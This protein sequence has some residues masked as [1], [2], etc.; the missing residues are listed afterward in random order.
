MATKITVGKIGLSPTKIAIP[1]KPNKKNKK[2]NK[3]EKAQANRKHI[4]GTK[5]QNDHWHTC[6]AL[7]KHWGFNETN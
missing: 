7:E 5:I 1:L 4:Q 6:N 3:T 2:I